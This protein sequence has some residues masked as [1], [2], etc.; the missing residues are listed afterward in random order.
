MT[1]E[2][3]GE[4]IGEEANTT[5]A[6]EHWRAAIALPEPG[7]EG[8]VWD[9]TIIG[10]SDPAHLVTIGGQE[11]ILSNNRRLYSVDG[12]RA[13]V[14][15]WEGTIVYDN[16][17]TDAEFKE[18][19]GMRSFLTEGIGALTGA[20]W[21]ADSRSLRANL[22]VVDDAARAKLLNAHNAGVLQH[23]GLSVDTDPIKG[24]PVQY[25]GHRMPTMAGF[26]RIYSVDLVSEPAAGGRFNRLIA[27]I[28]NGG[29]QMELTREDVERM[30]AEALA[31]R[32]APPT[33]EQA[34]NPEEAAAEV[35]DAATQA[36]MD[37]LDAG[38]PAPEVAQ[39]AADA[40]VQAADMIEEE[41]DTEEDVMENERET[42]QVRELEA[43][44]RVMECAAKLRN[45]L[46][47][48][49]LDGG[50]RSVI[51]AAFEGRPFETAALDKVIKRAKEA[52]AA[53][54]TTGRV[55]GNGQPRLPLA[56]TLSSLDKSAMGFLQLLNGP[57]RMR[58]LEANDAYYVRERLPEGFKAWQNA[59]RANYAPRN[60]PNWLYEMVG[61]PWHID[62]RVKE[63]ND[64]ASIT[65]NA[66]N[67][68][69]AA[70]YSVKNEWW[71]PIVTEEEVTDINQLT[72]VRTYG[73]E[74]LDVV[75]EG[76]AYTPID[77]SDDEET[78]TFIKHG[79]Y[80]RVTIE[81]MLKDK[82]NVFRNIPENLA[83]AWYNTLS[84]KVAA[85]FTVNTN[86][87]P[88]LSDTGALFNSAALTSA[89]G[90]ANLLT[91]AWSYTAFDA[92]RTAMM[93][94]TTKKL[95]TGSRM[96][97]RPKYALCPADLES[98]MLVVR[99]SEFKPNSAN[100][101]INPW[102]GAFDVLVVPEWTDTNNWALVADP[103][104]FPAIYL[105]FVSGY[106]VPEIYI[107]GDETGGAMFTNDTLRYKV[108]LMSYQFS[109]YD[110]APV[111]DF[112]PLHKSNV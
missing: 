79:N 101:D 27:A 60:L 11:Y 3:T 110:C 7:A 75:T 16:H 104:Q 73:F 1:H 99:N 68:M 69:L 45:K 35:V 17:L 14:P 28:H 41:E 31:A 89:G 66:L 12:L 67:V 85:V 109:S 63:A 44:L 57:R 93:K 65:K 10:P 9:I 47:A 61:D 34:D 18:R 95:G 53:I 105:A 25:E 111:A 19:A 102:Q 40:A 100:N 59:G 97:I 87:G 22:K 64:V 92:A 49:K 103:A 26:R 21:D 51:E 13:S 70:S 83:D 81:Q 55:S 91:T 39:A 52:Q 42:K 48:A 36:A 6:R 4:R 15:A 107:A 24:P 38:A 96:V 62:R 50:A 74:N 23:I 2:L 84:A 29:E 56:G 20:H 82:L 106:R 71:G 58:E 76:S 88:V 30:I 86:T 54:D 5:H 32:D 46:D 90:H 94:Q 33:T 98:A 77:L 72:L 112:R 8:R 108:R 80:A 78:A 43:R 37:A